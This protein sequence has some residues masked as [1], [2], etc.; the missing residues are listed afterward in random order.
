MLC[1]SRSGQFE[2][3]ST[4]GKLDRFKSLTVPLAY[5]GGDILCSPVVVDAPRAV[6]N[7]PRTPERPLSRSESTIF[8][9]GSGIECPARV[10]HWLRSWNTTSKIVARK[11]CGAAN[12]CSRSDKPVA[13][14]SDLGAVTGSANFGLVAQ[15]SER[16]VTIR[17]SNSIPASYRDCEVS[18]NSAAVTGENPVQSTNFLWLGA[19]I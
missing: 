10:D 18:D 9:A 16:S 8:S 14:D 12:L 1:K 15:H 7:V 5:N 19:I 2:L 11:V 17:S 6:S 4:R 3:S 13:D